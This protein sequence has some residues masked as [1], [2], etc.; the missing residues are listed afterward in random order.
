M[1][2]SGHALAQFMLDHPDQASQWNN[3]YLICLSV[4]DEEHLKKLMTKLHAHGITTSHFLEPDI[5]FELT[6]IAFEGTEKAA[7]LTSSFQ[8]A[9]KNIKN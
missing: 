8:L 3:N 1:S 9:L 6:A 4:D 7:K 2:Q 5:G